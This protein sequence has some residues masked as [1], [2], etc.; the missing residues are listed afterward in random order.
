MAGRENMQ[1]A[2]DKLCE[3]ASRWGLEFNVKKCKVIHMGSNNPEHEYT[4]NGHTLAAADEETDVGVAVKKNLKPSAQ[5]AKA[6]R[7]AQ[8][9][10]GQLVRAFHYRDRH[11][12]MRLYC[13]YVRPHLE[14]AAT[15]WSPWLEADKECLEKVQR[16]AVAMVTGLQAREYKERLRE[17]GMVSLEERRHQN[18]MVQVFKI[19]TEKDQVKKETW[20]VMANVGE[21]VTRATE[22]PLNIRIPAPRLEVRRNFFSQRVPRR[23]NKIPA[24]L[25]KVN[26]VG[27]FK[28]G[29]KKLRSERD[30]MDGDD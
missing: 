7:T 1:K 26:T 28:N 24:A 12:F 17:L 10:L 21:R 5:C 30:H 8:A 29:Y 27:A 18:D 20:F 23:W 6:A 14:F 15:S 9:V 3:W 11:I 16:R 13:Q 2:L 22:D 25:K 4:K 19:L